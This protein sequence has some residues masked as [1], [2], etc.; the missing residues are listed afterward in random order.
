MFNIPV[1]KFLD[2]AK[3]NKKRKPNVIHIDKHTEDFSLGYGYSNFCIEYKNQKYFFI[4]EVNSKE[5]NK[6]IFVSEDRKKKTKI[7]FSFS[8]LN[9]ADYLG[10]EFYY[11]DILMFKP[12]ALIT[13]S[14]CY[15]EFV[16]DITN[17]KAMS[18]LEYFLT[19]ETTILKSQSNYIK[20]K[21]LAND[22][23]TDD[24][25]ITII[26]NLVNKYLVIGSEVFIEC[27]NE[28][29]FYQNHQRD[30]VYKYLKC[31]LYGFLN[32]CTLYTYDLS[33]CGKRLYKLSVAP[34]NSSHS[35]DFYLTI[36][37]ENSESEFYIIKDD[38]L[39]CQTVDMDMLYSKKQLPYIPSSNK[40]ISNYKEM[41]CDDIMKVLVT[42]YLP[43]RYYSLL[44]TE[45]Y[46]PLS[47]AHLNTLIPLTAEHIQNMKLIEEKL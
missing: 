47:D 12:S 25:K 16:E 23:L 7:V 2:F 46:V 40:D 31:H 14:T 43:K 17:F 3:I 9:K 34:K 33:S 10:I 11:N 41:I 42:Y 39:R 45:Y 1:R 24:R 26:N 5:P 19:L 13:V 4:S 35:F 37:D 8:D 15:S 27:K 32:N 38:K 21:I 29:S 28:L 36:D 20:H 44:D 30:W 6:K 22:S 18:V